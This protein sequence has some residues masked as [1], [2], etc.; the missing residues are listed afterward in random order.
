MLARWDRHALADIVPRAWLVISASPARLSKALLACF[1]RGETG[2]RS[3]ITGLAGAVLGEGEAEGEGEKGDDPGSD[4]PLNCLRNPLGTVP[5]EVWDRM[6][7]M[8][9]R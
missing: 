1:S 2:F 9:S 3:S 5:E 4:T 7:P 8:S 6:R